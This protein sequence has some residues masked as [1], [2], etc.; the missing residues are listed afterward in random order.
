M[1]QFIEGELV[2]QFLD[3]LLNARVSPLSRSVPPGQT[4]GANLAQVPELRAGQ[5]V[6]LPVDKPIKKTGGQGVEGQRVV[7]GGAQRAG[8]VGFARGQIS[9]GRPN[10]WQQALYTTHH[11]MTPAWFAYP[12]GISF[13]VRQG[14]MSHATIHWGSTLCDA[15]ATY[16]SVC[17]PHRM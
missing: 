11:N 16:R 8:S 15:G 6:V 2:H 13:S 10:Q 1:S 14:S 12:S 5:D 9:A 17:A 7:G 4:M 3:A